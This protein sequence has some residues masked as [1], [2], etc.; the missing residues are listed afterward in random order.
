MTEDSF[1]ETANQYS[2]DPGSNTNGGLYT[3]VST[4]DLVEAFDAWCFD[5][6]RKA[7][8]YGIVSTELGFHIMYLSGIHPLW[9]DYV[10]SD[11]MGQSGADLLAEV[12]GKYPMTVD[13]GKITLGFVDMNK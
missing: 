7:G 11:I 6:A 12:T 9:K 13:F 1:A 10:L 4:G 8:D 2:V 5:P 3:G